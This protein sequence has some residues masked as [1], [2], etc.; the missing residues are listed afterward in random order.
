[1]ERIDTAFFPLP[2]GIVLESASATEIE[3][4][5]QIVC[6]YLSAACPQC[7]CLSQRLHSHYVRTVADLPCTGRRVVLRLSVR[8][9]VCAT[10]TC[11]QWIFTERLAS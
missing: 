1:M 11:P 7:Q 6:Q 2:E 5:V 4:V 8:K 10:P 9:F 3:V